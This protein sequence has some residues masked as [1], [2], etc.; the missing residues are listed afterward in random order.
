MKDRKGITLIELVL[1]VALLG[2]TI[3]A[4]YSIFFV[5]NTSYGVS[6]SKGFAQQEVRLA[7]DF[8]SKNL[9]YATILSSDSEYFTS[10]Y[11]SLRVI[12]GVYNDRLILSYHLLNDNGTEDITDD[13]VDEEIINEIH[14]KWGNIEISYSK[15]ESEIESETTDIISVNISKI[16][17]KDNSNIIYELP[18]K[19]KTINNNKMPNDIDVDFYSDDVLYFKLAKNSIQNKSI[20]ISDSTPVGNINEVLVNYYDKS[21]TPIKSELI[22]KGTEIVLINLEY[23][24]NYLFKGWSKNEDLSGN[25]Y[26]VDEKIII[27]NDTN[28]YA[29]WEGNTNGEPFI[30]S[31]MIDH[32]GIYKNHNNNKDRYIL[33]KNAG[34]FE[35]YIQVK[36]QNLQDIVVNLSSLSSDSRIKNYYTELNSTMEFKAFVEISYP[37]GNNTIDLNATVNGIEYYFYFVTP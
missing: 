2:I 30:N 21:I 23:K 19:I 8:I 32:Y 5:G 31:V 34:T 28:F 24:D 13:Y 37:Q 1:V 26:A 33:E 22:S 18:I 11:Y 15:T 4:I 7:S 36:G 10:G 35:T 12:K 3:Q 25:I 27:N 16:D 6:K 29:V 20:Y 17:E 9:K 14:G